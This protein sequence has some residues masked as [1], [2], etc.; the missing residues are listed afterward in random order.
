[1][2]KEYIK[3]IRVSHWVK[4]IFVFVPLVFSK[5][6]LDPNY[7]FT[8]LQAFFVFSLV[9]SAVYIFNDINDVEEDKQHPIKKNRPI[10]SEKISIKIAYVLLC[11]LIIVVALILIFNFNLSFV[12]VLSSYFV[13]NF[14]YTTFLKRLVIIDIII[15][16]IGFMLR[17]LAGVY[18]I[19]VYISNWLILSA[20]FISLFLAIMKRKSELSFNQSGLL[21]RKV[22]ENYSIDFL[23]QISTISAAGVI[24]CYTLYSI[25]ERT[26]NFFKTDKLIYSTLFVIFGIFRYLYLSYNS[27]KDRNIVNVIFTDK[28]MLLNLLAYIF[29]IIIVVYF[30]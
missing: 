9:T 23:N 17:V 26:I 10:A 24:V 6:L 30:I 1:M 15:I 18:A 2:I 28:P 14:F 5:H 7:F 19:D 13:L 11:L 16:A 27:E 4:N 3:L 29:F 20:I 21:T 12:F 22:L 25:S 8:S